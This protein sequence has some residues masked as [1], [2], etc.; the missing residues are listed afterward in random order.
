[1][2]ERKIGE[3]FIEPYSKLKIICVKDKY[4]EN[5]L[6]CDKCI[7]CDRINDETLGPCNGRLRSD[8]TNVHFEE[9]NGKP[10]NGYP[11]N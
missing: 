6:D 2:A 1:M 8:K 9:W 3:V 11:T 10:N 4:D 7:G 5:L